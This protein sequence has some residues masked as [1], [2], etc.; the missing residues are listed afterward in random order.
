MSLLTSSPTLR[1]E[2]LWLGDW[3]VKNF[4]MAS[5]QRGRTEITFRS[6]EATILI[7]VALVLI[8]VWLLNRSAN[9]KTQRDR[10]SSRRPRLW[11]KTSDSG[12]SS[13]FLFGSSSDSSQQGGDS[14]HH[15][16]G[17]SHHGSHGDAGHSSTNSPSF[18][19][20]G[21]SHGGFDG[22]GGHH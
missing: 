8:V 19:G 3:V 21:H 5:R 6:M 11:D 18:D 7:L 13:A 4:S 15:S 1:V 9:S 16:P 20:G 10:R 2:T 14:S 12:A 22:G 17:S